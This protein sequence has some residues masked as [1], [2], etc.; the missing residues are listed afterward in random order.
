MPYFSIVKESYQLAHD[1]LFIY[2]HA[3]YRM[4]NFVYL[5]F[6]II[7]HHFYTYDYG[8]FILSIVITVWV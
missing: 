5:I 6:I 8:I 7:L 4:G 1:T 2:A 3:T